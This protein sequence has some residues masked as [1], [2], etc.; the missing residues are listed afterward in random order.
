MTMHGMNSHLVVFI[1]RSS[2]KLNWI[3]GL[4]W[5]IQNKI[6]LSGLVSTGKIW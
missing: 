2:E 1:N 6:W 4:W 3:I 5:I